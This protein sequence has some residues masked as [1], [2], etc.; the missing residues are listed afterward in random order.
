MKKRRV[1]V[2]VI[3]LFMLY[4]IENIIG[5]CAYSVRNESCEA[6]VIIVLGA[7]AYDGGVSPVYRERL[8]H[9]IDLYRQGLAEKMIVTGGVAKGNQHSDA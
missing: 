7:A 4:I 2:S 9:G 5:I 6:D 8:N 3:F 1:F